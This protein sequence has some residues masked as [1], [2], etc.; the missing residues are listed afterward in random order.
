[1]CDGQNDAADGWS[2][3]AHPGSAELIGSRIDGDAAGTDAA[4]SVGR[5][6]ARSAGF[7]MVPKLGIALLVALGLGLRIWILGRAPLTSDQ[8]VVGLM[9]REILHGHFFVFYWGQHYGG[10]EP[11]VVA[12]LFALLGESRLALGLVPL[13]LDALAALLVWRIGRRLFD[14]RVAVLA[15]LLF[16]LWPEVYLYLSTVEYGFRL[17]ALVCGLAALLFALRLTGPRPQRL[18]DWAALGLVLGLGW[19]CSPEIAYYAVPVLF[20]LV[21]RAVRDRAWPRLAAVGL[22]A[23]AAVLGAL[24]WLVANVGSG[25]PSL[26]AGSP[27]HHAS[28]AER[29]GVFFRDVLPLAQGVRLRGTGAWLVPGVLGMAL[30]LLIAGLILYWVLRLALERR[31]L[32]LVAFVALFPFAYAASPYSW[33]WIDGRYAFYLAP[34]LALLVASGLWELGSRRPRLARAAPAAGLIAALA[35]TAGAAVRLA[36][37]IPLAG[38]DGARSGWTS[39]R[40]DPDAWLRPLAAALERSHAGGAYAGYWLAYPLTFESHGR[41]VASDPAVDRYPPYQTAVAQ[42]PRQAWVFPRPSPS[43]LLALNAA[44]GAHPWLVGR[45]WSLAD[46]ESYLTRQ[47]VAYRTEDAGYFTIVYPQRAVPPA[48]VL[49]PPG[50]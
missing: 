14:R 1:M 24:P 34:V 8:A 22:F 29:L 7:G 40:A 12:A 25:F 20:W 41:V 26:R 31:A 44:A 39:W 16:W 35:L 36:P 42:S 48:V 49:S 18:L 37:Y 43:S 47:G 2:A 46:F 10:G 32:L 6:G 19:W 28:W 4:P 13:L 30:Y 3:V 50:T 33:Y 45:G 11:Y 23:V 5:A 27:A 15:A 9:A 38:S 17:L 21:Y